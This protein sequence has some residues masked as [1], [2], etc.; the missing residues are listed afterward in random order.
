MG[1]F[2]QN[3]FW[4]LHNSEVHCAMSFDCLHAFQGG[5]FGQ[6]L[7]KQFKAQVEELGRVKTAQVDT[8]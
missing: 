3:A 4:S 1:V 5:L 7:F 8:Q 6:H 2:L